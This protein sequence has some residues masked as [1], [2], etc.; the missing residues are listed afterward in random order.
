MEKL[1]DIVDEAISKGKQMG[2]SPEELSVTL[3]AR[4][5]T[6]PAAKE[7]ARPRLLFVECNQP[8]LDLFSAELK[9]ALSVPIESMLLQDLNRMLRRAPRSIQ[10]YALVMTTFYHIHEI[11][12]SLAKSGV[13]VMGLLVEAGLETLIR[14]TALPEGTKVGVACDEWAGSENM[15]LSI[16]NAGLKHLHLV[17][18]CGRDKKTL[19]KMINEVSIIVS[20]ILVEEKLRAMAPRDKEIIVDDRRLD[21][22]GIEMIRSRLR[23]L[24]AAGRIQSKAKEGYDGRATDFSI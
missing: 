2:F 10:Q 24:S 13:E 15:K 21:T 6:A 19:K 5:R 1:L 14:L 9:V 17:L 8:Q 20:S 18:G 23:K 7:L 11:Q 3:Y 4:T 16:E 12:N 22:A